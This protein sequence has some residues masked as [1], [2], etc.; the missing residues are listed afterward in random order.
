MPHSNKLVFVYVQIL[1]LHIEFALIKGLEKA[2]L[3]RFSRAAD[4]AGIKLLLSRMINNLQKDSSFGSDDSSTPRRRDRMKI[5]R[6][7]T[8]WTI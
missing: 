2:G 7:R 6:S 5:S 3:E 1:N 4:C 8:S